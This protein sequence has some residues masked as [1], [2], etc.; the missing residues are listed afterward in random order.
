M[1]NINIFSI[2][3]DKQL[4][5]TVIFVFIDTVFRNGYE[6]PYLMDS[7]MVGRGIQIVCWQ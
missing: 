7:A 2:K 4:T 3:P 6:I 5:D 1:I